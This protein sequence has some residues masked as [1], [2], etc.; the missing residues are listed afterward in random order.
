MRGPDAER[1]EGGN[2]RAVSDF[3]GYNG[4]SE[5]VARRIYTTRDK[6]HEML[7]YTVVTRMRQ[8]SECG[9]FLRAFVNME[10][11]RLFPL[12]KSGPSPGHPYGRAGHRADECM[13]CPGTTQVFNVRR[14][15]DICTPHI[16]LP[17]IDRFTHP[18]N[19]LHRQRHK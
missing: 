11:W 10:A 14:E 16:H 9:G 1:I 4:S 19:T 12:P 5:E 17:Q 18:L 8:P 7:R 3:E 13:T 6:E 15:H 2:E